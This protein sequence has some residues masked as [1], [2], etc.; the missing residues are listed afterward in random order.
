MSM[1]TYEYYEEETIKAYNILAKMYRRRVWKITDYLKKYMLINNN[2]YIADIGCGRG[3]Y[4]EYILSNTKQSRVI[5]IDLAENMIIDLY[6]RIRQKHRILPIIA[7]AEELPIASSKLGLALYIAVL[8]HILVKEKRKKVLK[9][10]YRCL[11]D[12]GIIIITVWAF[13]QLPFIKNI[14]KYYL[15]RLAKLIGIKKDPMIA[16]IFWK[17]KLYRRY[18]YL[19]TLK[20]LVKEVKSAKLSILDKKTFY[21]K[22][23]L[24]NPTKNY[25]IIAIK[26]KC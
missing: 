18:Y 15:Y 2:I 22:K 19:F 5:A 7:S 25:L 8:H 20:E 26:E 13:N 10:G 23:S 12:K 3:Q 11:K 1:G 14:V 9:E 6:G 4:V 17:G 16:R 24:F 21:E